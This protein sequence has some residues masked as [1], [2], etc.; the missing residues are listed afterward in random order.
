MKT[1]FNLIKN[2]LLS[3]HTIELCNEESEPNYIIRSKS[4]SGNN[5]ITFFIEQYDPITFKKNYIYN[6]Q[7]FK[8][9]SSDNELV[10]FLMFLN[11]FLQLQDEIKLNKFS[12]TIQF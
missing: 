5:F 10:Q 4:L 8:I 2:I 12:L 6:N 11:F 9:S 7:T 1:K 3:S